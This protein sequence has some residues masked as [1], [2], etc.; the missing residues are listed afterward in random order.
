LII[1][2]SLVL[3]I[4]ALA[5]SSATQPLANGLSLTVNYTTN[6]ITGETEPE[7]EVTIELRDESGELKDSALVSADESGQFLA[8][9]ADIVPGDRV[10]ASAGETF[11]EINPVG[12]LEGQPWADSDRVIATLHAAWFE[13]SLDVSCGVYEDDPPVVID[14][15]A[16]ADGG[17]FECDFSGQWDLQAPHL[18]A[19]AYSEPDGD[20]VIR[21]LPWPWMRVNYTHDRPGMNYPRG[22]F[23]DVFVTDS[24]GVT[25][26]GS[27]VSVSVENGGWDGDGFDTVDWSGQQPDIQP[28][29][30]VVFLADDGFAGH[31]WVGEI[32]GILD[33]DTDA[34]QGTVNA[35]EV[36]EEMLPVQCQPWGAWEAGI[37]APE[38]LSETPPDDDDTTPFGCAWDSAGEWDILPGQDL[39]VLYIES[40]LDRVIRVFHEAAPRL[41]ISQWAQGEVVAGGNVA[42]RMRMSNEGDAAA[43]NVSLGTTLL[44]LSY[45]GDTSALAHS[46]SGAGPISWDLGTLNPGMAV[47]FDAFF[48][49]TA[50]VGEIVSSALEIATTSYD[51]GDPADKTSFW[52]RVVQD[53]I[54]SPGI[55]K[56]S[57]TPDPAPGGHLTYV[58]EVCNNAAYFSDLVTVTD[59]TDEFQALL[60]WWA[61]EAGWMEVSFEPAQLVVT[62]P[63]LPAYTCHELYV[64]AE[65]DAGVEP[66]QML[67]NSV[68]LQMDG[69]P[70]PDDNYYELKLQAASPHH[71]LAVAKQGG[72]G[73]PIPGGQLRYFIDV[74]NTGNI[75]IPD[76]F[77]VTD[78]FPP[79]TI[80]ADSWFMDGDARVPLVPLT[81]TDDVVTWQV[82]GLDNGAHFVIELLLIVDHDV[83]PGLELVNHVSV[84]ELV[85]EDSYAD[86]GASWQD[87]LRPFG[88]NL[89][90][91]KSSRLTDGGIEYEI[92]FA[93]PGS[94]TVE[95]VTI[96]DTLPP[97]VSYSGDWWHGS[98]FNWERL[99]AYEQ[100]DDQLV[101]QL[102][103][104]RP[105]EAGA[106]FFRVGLVEPEVSHRFVNVVEITL[107][108]GD[109]YPQD[110]V[111][112]DV[113]FAG[114][115][116]IFQDGFESD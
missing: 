56:W 5:A 37:D 80:F 25:E 63:A 98:D 12:R 84:E 13:G 45:I 1:V 49:V 50:G 69:D 86:N 106:L 85:G 77:Q 42:I 26:K 72:P 18:V 15:T 38:K 78:T 54:A 19:V 93:N 64:Q 104:I 14:S 102:S 97:L 48:D 4:S 60:G 88:P 111:A 89:A 2:L 115:D 61:S 51:A 22:H 100:A 65:V 33:T 17:G 114:G 99:A 47:E 76:T 58:I 62:I 52:E 79:G 116:V 44:G 92:H 94:A 10:S 87:T 39:A 55:A 67:A 70:D 107:P 16:I 75:S 24:S 53:G 9:T 32:K 20:R 27:G 91:D 57:V 29:D 96:A 71:N 66:G 40:D 105:G 31:L 21:E 68:T 36:A 95:A 81:I 108:E 8:V 28:F 101:W 74:V 41:G 6:A 103:E 83:E 35:P 34:I 90:V 82:P 23:F 46:G 110:N 73:M 112:Q 113:I 30:K 109:T 59:T 43:E 3:S 7:A 11:A